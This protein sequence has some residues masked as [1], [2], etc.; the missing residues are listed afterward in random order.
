MLKG[1]RKLK[2]DASIKHLGLAMSRTR[3]QLEEYKEE[4]ERKKLQ[5]T[6]S[7]KLKSQEL[8]LNPKGETQGSTQAIV[9]LTQEVNV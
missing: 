2:D 9:P 8:S 5:E 7:K 1:L 6:R 3:I 4:R